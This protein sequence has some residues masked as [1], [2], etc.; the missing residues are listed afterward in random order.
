[1]E[2]AMSLLLNHPEILKKARTEI[3]TI[4]GHARMIKESDLPELHYL[5]NIISE[6]LR[7]CQ[8]GPSLLPHEASDDCSIGG[9]CVPRGT[10]LFVNVWAIQRDPEFW[11][12]PTRFKP[13]RF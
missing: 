2:W 8:P 3:D 12:E 7:L 10:I 1:M 5:K 11:D 13:E 9:Y 4:V 6:T